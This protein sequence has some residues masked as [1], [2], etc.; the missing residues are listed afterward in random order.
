MMHCSTRPH[1]LYKMSR[2][3]RGKSIE[4][5][6]V[7]VQN[8]FKCNCIQ[9]K[10]SHIDSVYQKKL[11]DGCGAFSVMVHIQI[12]PTAAGRFLVVV[13]DLLVHTKMALRHTRTCHAMLMFMEKALVPQEWSFAYCILFFSSCSIAQQLL[14]RAFLQHRNWIGEAVYASN[15]IARKHHQDFPLQLHLSHVHTHVHAHVSHGME[16]YAFQGSI[17]AAILLKT[18]QEGGMVH[19]NE[20]ESD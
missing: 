9:N 5:E 14:G 17:L 16:V 1:L 6:L 13:E 12:W 20:E 7:Y 4:H 11:L 15:H 8:N 10:F 19:N 2:G 3:T 18:M